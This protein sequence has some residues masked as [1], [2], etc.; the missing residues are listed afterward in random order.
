M[1]DISEDETVGAVI[2]TGAGRGFCSGADLG[3]VIVL[4]TI[5]EIIKKIATMEKPVIALVNGVAAGAGCDLTM[6]CDLRIASDKAKL[7]EIFVKRGLFPD[8]GGTYFLPRLVGLSK[9]KE[10]IFT[11]EMIDAKEAGRIGLVDKV[12]PADELESTGMEL[13][14]RLAKGPTLAIGKAK[15][16]INRAIESNLDS[17]LKD[18]LEAMNF[19]LGT[20]DAMEGIA[21]FMEKR[22]PKFKGK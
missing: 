20:E 18:A 15:V 3:A 22:E 12:V 6:A 8:C 5:H 13:A 7:S 14:R 1:E 2:I 4:S 16:A 10:L 9:A 11:G 19:I 17:A 21:A